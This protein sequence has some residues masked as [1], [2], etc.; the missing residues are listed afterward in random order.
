MPSSS[1][2]RCD[3][4]AHMRRKRAAFAAVSPLSPTIPAI[5]HIRMLRFSL[6]GRDLGPWFLSRHE[7][8]RR[9]GRGY[10]IRDPLP[11]IEHIR[12]LDKARALTAQK[13]ACHHNEPQ[14][15]LLVFLP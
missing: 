5:P 4:T 9:L 11:L 12:S 14:D 7:L 13:S 2:P 15:I 6:P 3:I 10:A 1:G 8:E